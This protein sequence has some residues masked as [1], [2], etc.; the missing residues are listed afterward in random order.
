MRRT[1]MVAACASAAL[2][3]ACGSS[4]T[5]SAISPQRFIAFGDAVSD[6]GQKGSRYTVND[7]NGGTD[8]ANVTLTVTGTNDAPVAVA[9]TAAATEDAPA[10]T[11]SVATNDSDVD[12]GAVLSVARVVAGTTDDP[13]AGNLAGALAGSYG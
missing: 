10:V 9:D 7:G 2:L 11:G 5:E 4:T 12:A 1:F 6:V 8:T 13:A 3:A